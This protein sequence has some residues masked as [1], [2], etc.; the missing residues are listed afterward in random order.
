MILWYELCD[1]ENRIVLS[2][3]KSWV[4][5]VM[6]L[7]AAWPQAFYTCPSPL[8]KRISNNPPVRRIMQYA[9]P[10]MLDSGTTLRRTVKQ[11]SMAQDTENEFKL[12]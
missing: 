3:L 12:N 6:P 5:S 7:T 1:L 10:M 2:Y 4:K 9:E 11:Y 8:F